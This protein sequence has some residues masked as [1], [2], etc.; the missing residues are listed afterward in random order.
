M[1]LLLLLACQQESKV[2]EDATGYSITVT[3]EKD[4][5][6]PDATEGYEETFQ[7]FIALDGSSASIYIDEQLFASGIVSGCAITYQTPIIGE[8]TEKDGNVKWQLFGEAN[9]DDGS[10]ACV[11]G[12]NDW[13]GTEYFEIVSTE[14]DTLE[15]GCEYQTTTAGTVL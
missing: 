10:D 12:K 6:H 5:C 9:F 15:P 7:Y 2:P 8:D 14:N 1:T 3:A 11:T 13:E 4:E